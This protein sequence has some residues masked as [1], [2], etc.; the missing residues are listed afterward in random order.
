MKCLVGVIDAGTNSVR[1]V[2][3]SIPNFEEICVHEMKISQISIKDGWLEH[4]PLEIMH[5]VRECA[6]VAM[7]LLPNHGYSK[8][9]LATIGI[10]NPRETVVMWNKQTGAPLYNAIG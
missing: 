10:T 7:H 8:R 4:D 6:K 5:A 2:I 1:F 3:Y 9:N